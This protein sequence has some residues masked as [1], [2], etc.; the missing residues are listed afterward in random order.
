MSMIIDDRTFRSYNSVIDQNY[1]SCTMNQ[2]AEL[3][4]S[5]QLS[6]CTFENS[7]L[8]CFNY[9]TGYVLIVTMEV[10]ECLYDLRFYW[11]RLTCEGVYANGEGEKYNNLDLFGKRCD[12][13][14]P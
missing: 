3:G 14:N 13:C 9:G 11:R 2:Q 7:N 1:Q 4:C 10:K 6:M 5:L 8:Y 12:S